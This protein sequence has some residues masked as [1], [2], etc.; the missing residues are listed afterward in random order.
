MQFKF[1]QQNDTRLHD[2]LST[3]LGFPSNNPIAGTNFIP[4]GVAL[5]RTLLQTR[6]RDAAA[7]LIRVVI[8]VDGPEIMSC[9]IQ[10]ILRSKQTH[11]YAVILVVV[12]ES[13]VTPD[14]GNALN[15]TYIFLQWLKVFAI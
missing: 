12:F 9:I 11:E 7:L 8:G 2:V 14:G 1:F 4:V 13:S 10:N 5:N 6:F 15:R 3:P